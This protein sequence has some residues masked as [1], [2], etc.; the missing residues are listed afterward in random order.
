MQTATPSRASL[1][2]NARPATI[3]KSSVEKYVGLTTW[4]SVL[5]RWLSSTGASPTTS[6][7]TPP[8]SKK[9]SGSELAQPTSATPGTARISAST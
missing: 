8:S 6:Y 3:G 2:S 1:R 9:S 5:G 4:Y 7:D